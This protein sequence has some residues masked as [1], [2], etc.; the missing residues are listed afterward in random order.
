MGSISKVL[1]SSASPIAVGEF[2]ASFLA[3]WGRSGRK[4]AETIGLAVSGGVD[5]MALAA[6]C[7]QIN[8]FPEHH[9]ASTNHQVASRPRD[10]IYQK[11]KF[12]AFVVDHG[13]RNGSDMEATAVSE[14]L[15][16][17]GIITQVL[18]IDWYGISNPASLTNFETLARKYRFQILGKACRDHGINSLL[19]AHHEDDQVETTIMRLLAGQRGSGLA[20][21]KEVSEIPECHGIWG[22]HES[23][24]VPNFL[25]QSQINFFNSL[26]KRIIQ[27]NRKFDDSKL[28]SPLLLETGGVRIYR[29]LLRFP[30]D[31]LIAT[32]K[33]E[34]MPWFEDLTNKDPTVTTRNAIR[35]VYN[36]YSMPAA[37]SKPSLL[38]RIQ[39]LRLKKEAILEEAKLLFEKCSITDFDL[40]TGTLR[41]RFCSLDPPALDS[42]VLKSRERQRAVTVELLRIVV[43]LVTPLENVSLPSLNKSLERVFPQRFEGIITPA[44]TIFTVAGLTFEPLSSSTDI[45]NP[46]EQIQWR[47]SRQPYTSGVPKPSL[48]IPP[49]SPSKTQNPWSDWALYDGRYWIRVKNHTSSPISVRPLSKVDIG[50][51]RKSLIHHNNLAFESLLKNFAVGK[52]RWTLPALVMTDAGMEKAVALPTAG[53]VGTELHGLDWEVRYKK[54]DSALRDGLDFG[55]HY[56]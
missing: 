38:Q 51:F 42:K 15:E 2:V 40:R 11:L 37:L 5:S 46:W 48:S 30:K 14:V 54:V 44:P 16:E 9:H 32:C 24:G 28:L 17:R 41:I 20:G 27:T 52:V 7:S 19:L 39:K 33:A 22:V 31:R 34:E 47:V 8:Q 29:P 55:I 56:N 23:G 36:S 21:M 4:H 26:P 1:P 12:R 18:K 3:I 10:K 53:I 25:Q 43:M 50:P 6:L 35:Y 49:L 13:A 45:S